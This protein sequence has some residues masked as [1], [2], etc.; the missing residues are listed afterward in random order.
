MSTLVEKRLA[1]DEIRKSR[2]LLA[3]VEPPVAQTLPN[4]G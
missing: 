1:G 2:W 4:A 3:R